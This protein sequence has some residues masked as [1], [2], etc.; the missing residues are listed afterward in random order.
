MKN[1]I[2][3]LLVLF[4]IS[5]TAFAQEGI[6]KM[7]N[8]GQRHGLWK[9]IHE[10]SKRPRYEGTFNHG[11]ETGIFKYFDDTAAGKVIA[12]RDFTAKDGSCYTIFYDQKG[13]KVSEGR[14]LNRMHEGEWKYYHKESPVIMAIEKYSKGK[15][16]GV[17]KVFH[18]NK[19]INE[20][21]TYV[22]GVKDGPYKKYTENGVV[23]EEAIYKEGEFHGPAVYKNENGQLV[24]KGNFVNGKKMGMWQFYENGKLLKEVNMSDPKNKQ[25]KA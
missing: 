25:K 11:K 6:N 3:A 14:E 18:P 4:F 24:A 12:T 21:T 10:E 16:T 1:R 22:N 23:I 17:R 20:E 19:T 5:I 2:A 15:L 13:N 8:E 9:G 7:D